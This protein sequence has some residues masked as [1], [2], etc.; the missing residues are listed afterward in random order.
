MLII[1]PS[2]LSERSDLRDPEN[3]PRLGGKARALF[4]LHSTRLP[5]PEAFALS[6][7]AF[8][9]SLT[10]DQHASLA[11]GHFPPVTPSEEVEAALK[12]ALGALCPHG[13]RVAV[14]SSALDEDGSEHSFAG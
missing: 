1:R 4:A 14:R 8:E 10:P 6:P 2:D 11:A 13:E 9:R 7:E 12:D 5:I 3:D